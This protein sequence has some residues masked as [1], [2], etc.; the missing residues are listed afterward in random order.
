MSTPI[1]DMLLFEAASEFAEWAVE[2]ASELAAL[3]RAARERTEA[4]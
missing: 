3:E 4:Q 1:D 2:H